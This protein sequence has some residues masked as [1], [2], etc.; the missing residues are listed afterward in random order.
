MRDLVRIDPPANPILALIQRE[1]GMANYHPVVAIARLSQD[2]RM[3]EDPRLELECHKAI[4]PYVAPKLSSIEINNT[5]PDD[6]RIL[7]SLFEERTLDNGVVVDV[8][9][10]LVTEIEDVVMLDS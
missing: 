1:P 2:P 3:R 4:L 5:N 10:P 6:R 7:V 8:E 9:V